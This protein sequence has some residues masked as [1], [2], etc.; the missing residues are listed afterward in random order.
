MF[1]WIMIAACLFAAVN[2]AILPNIPAAHQYL[3]H[4]MNVWAAVGVA[5]IVMI[6]SMIF[7]KNK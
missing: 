2:W 7:G 5:G 3:P 6:L 1:K 4:G